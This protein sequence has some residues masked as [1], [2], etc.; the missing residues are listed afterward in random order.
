MRDFCWR[1]FWCSE[2][3]VH[4]LLPEAPEVEGGRKPSHLHGQAK[5]ENVC[6]CVCV[7]QA[8]LLRLQVDSTL[9]L[10]NL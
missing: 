9:S 7:F 8:V 2:E 6:V 1:E 5:Q 4:V 10:R 3:L